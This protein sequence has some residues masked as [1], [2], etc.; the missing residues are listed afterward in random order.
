MILIDGDR[1]VSQ[2]NFLR[3]LFAKGRSITRLEAMHYGIANLT[4]RISEL[5]GDGVNVKCRWKQ[6]L[7]GARYGEFSVSPEDRAPLKV[8]W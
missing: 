2:R 8:Y 4:A 6:D 3:R 1:M 5:R 7:S